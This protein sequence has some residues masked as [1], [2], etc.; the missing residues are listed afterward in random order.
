MDYVAVLA[1]IKSCCTKKLLSRRSD[2]IEP[3]VAGCFVGGQDDE[4]HKGSQCNEDT[5]C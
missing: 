5:L 2:V 4:Q 3:G 1:T